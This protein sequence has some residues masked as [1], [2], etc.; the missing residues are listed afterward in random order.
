[1]VSILGQIFAQMGRQGSGGWKVSVLTKPREEK[2]M[3]FE[4]VFPY[5]KKGNGFS[6]Y[7]ES[8]A[9]KSGLQLIEQCQ[10]AT[11]IEGEWEAAMSFLRRCQEYVI[12]HEP[13]LS[14]VTTVH[15]HN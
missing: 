14:A 12:Q 10:S 2:W 11:I 15:I 1:M 3:V 13:S 9:S 4:F 6:Q 5:S 8:L 7:V